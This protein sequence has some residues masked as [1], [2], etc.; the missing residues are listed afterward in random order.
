MSLLK[1][2]VLKDLKLLPYSQHMLYSFKGRATLT[3][4]A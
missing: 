4:T 1:M 3:R 2:N